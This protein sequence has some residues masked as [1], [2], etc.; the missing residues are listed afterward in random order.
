MSQWIRNLVILLVIQLALLAFLQF[1]NSGAAPEPE[2]FI[3]LTADQ[4]GSV[5]V[6]DN[7]GNVAQLMRGDDGWELASGLPVDKAK[8]D[9]LLE[10]LV[11]V[12][13]GWPVSTSSATHERFEVAPEKYQRR[14]ELASSPAEDAREVLL[15]GTSPGYQQIH[16][17]ADSDDV[18]AVKLATYDMPAEL[19]DW[20]DKTLLQSAGAINTVDW[21]GGL[22]LEE[23]DGSWRLGTQPAE[24]AAAKTAVDRVRN[25][26]VL[27]RAEDA[28]K[29]PPASA[30]TIMVSDSA[31]EYRLSFWER[32]AQ[33][34]YLIVSTRYPSETFRLASY[35][36]EELVPD[37]DDLEPAADAAAGTGVLLPEAAGVNAVPSSAP[38]DVE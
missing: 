31:G 4:I 27:G 17:R 14:L 34:D 7:E 30:S 29:A 37:R 21:G 23:K 5:K 19:D 8:I 2:A 20:L 13:L 28:P 32:E 16:A 15:F 33:N 22:V 1:S 25:V 6:S 10:K 24:S 11:S 9:G 38:P 12:T 36:A 35:L 18:Y 26:R 3:D